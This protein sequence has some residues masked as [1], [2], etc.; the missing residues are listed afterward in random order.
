[1]PL[2]RSGYVGS[3][4][5]KIYGISIV[6]KMKRKIHIYGRKLLRN[7]LYVMGSHIAQIIFS[8]VG[9]LEFWNKDINFFTIKGCLIGST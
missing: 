9:V 7:F 8:S 5:R 1:M 4:K 6:D 2:F 3:E